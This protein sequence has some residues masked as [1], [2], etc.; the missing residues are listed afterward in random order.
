MGGILR[1]GSWSQESKYYILI[2]GRSVTHICIN[3]L[4]H[5]RFGWQLP[6]YSMPSWKIS[7]YWQL[8]LNQS[9]GF[10]A[11]TQHASVG[12]LV[13]TTWCK[14]NENDFHP[15]PNHPIPP[16]H[17]PSL[18]LHVIINSEANLRISSVSHD[19]SMT[20]G[21]FPH[22][23]TFYCRNQTAMSVTEGQ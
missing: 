1:Q 10:D 13:H 5:R 16:A 3:E 22:Y 7:T 8:K 2:H 11:L 19:D 12:S 9:D 14:V 23:S 20:R 21:C 4:R 18:W 17:Q 6:I 15:I